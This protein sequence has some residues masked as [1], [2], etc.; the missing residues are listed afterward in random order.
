L[1]E[2]SAGP[3][4]VKEKIAYVLAMEGYVHGFPLVMMDVTR[5]VITANQFGRIRTSVGPWMSMSGL[6]RQALTGKRTG[7]PVRRAARSI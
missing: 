1:A 3:S 7:F 5:E 4:K 6:S 2:L